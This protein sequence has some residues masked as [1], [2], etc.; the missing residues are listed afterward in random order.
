MEPISRYERVVVLGARGQL[1]SALVAQ[2]WP[3]GMSVLPVTRDQLDLTD[4]EAVHDYLHDWRPE[5]VINAAGYASADRAE[6]EPEAAIELNHRAV[7]YV[8]EALRA[9]GGRLVHISTSDVFD[10]A[11]AGWYTEHDQVNPL[12]VYGRSMRKGELTA[13]GL[14]DSLVVRSSWLY[15]TSGENFVRTIHRL[16]QTQTSLEV[17]DDLLGC[18]T[19]VDE[20]A[21]AIVTAVGAGLPY[22]GLFHIAAPDHATWWEVAD[23]ILRFSGRRADVDLRR[24]RAA[25][26]QPLA[27]RPID[28]RLSSDAFAA[29]YGVTLSPW[30]QALRAVL[31]Q[32]QLTAIG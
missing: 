25:E 20:L 27:R 3:L 22:T 28:S 6:E 15:S 19:S 11:T 8:V 13:L 5:V 26:C 10:G 14:D 18:P 21:A 24:V 4:R 16:G 7:G 17:V 31:K 32:L 23:E 12:S 9:T 29:A 2:E 30:R 1:G